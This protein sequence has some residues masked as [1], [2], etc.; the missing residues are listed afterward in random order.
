MPKTEKLTATN[1]YYFLKKSIQYILIIILLL[2][3]S[4]KSMKVDC[5]DNDGDGVPNIVDKCPDEAGTID[6]YGCPDSDGDGIMDVDD[7]CPNTPGFMGGCPDSDGDGISDRM[8]ECPTQPGTS[9]NRG[10]PSITGIVLDNIGELELPPPN[11]TI[12]DVLDADIFEGITS[13]KE[14]DAK[15]RSALKENGYRANKYL[16]VENGFALITQLEQTD[17]MGVSVPEP[18]RWITE[19]YQAKKFSIREFFKLLFTAK[20]GHY[21]TFVFI[22]TTDYF[23]YSEETTSKDDIENL[24]IEGSPVLPSAIGDMSFTKDHKV[25]L[26]VYEFIKYEHENVVE[27]NIDSN[28]KNQHIKNSNI[29]ESLK[30]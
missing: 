5:P 8:D 28:I 21:R 24:Y 7:P 4:C 29:V 25:Y 18:N 3:T 11:P 14:L 2:G 23:K 1:H 12:F 30:N 15:L 17:E 16:F 20:P 6:G 19:V 22:V 26:N 27:F 13:M 10:C 9:E